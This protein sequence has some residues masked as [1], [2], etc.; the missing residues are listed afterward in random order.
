MMQTLKHFFIPHEGNNYHPHIL[1]TKR[2]FFYATAFLVMKLIVFLFALLLPLQVFVMPDVLKLQED[3]IIELTNEVRIR[4]GLSTLSRSDQLMTSSRLKVDDMIEHE[5]FDH[6]SPDGKH[7][8]DF[9]H[10]AGYIYQSAGENLGV[11]FLD[12][13]KLV[14]AWVDSPTHYANLVDTDYRDIGLGVNIGEYNGIPTA[15]VAQHFGMPEM[16][17]AGVKSEI[18]E[19]MDDPDYDDRAPNI[20]KDYV[21]TL[22]GKPAD[23]IEQENQIPLFAYNRDISRVYWKDMEDGSTEITA[24]AYIVG[25]IDEAIVRTNEYTINLFPSKD[26]YIYLGQIRVF[27]T[28]DQV[29][30][31]VMT[32]S[33]SIRAVSGEVLQDNIAWH[34]PKV[35]GPTPVEKYTSAKT[36]L[37]SVSNIFEVSRTVYLGFIIFFSIALL[38]K[39]LIE[40]RKQH[41]HVIFQ[42]VLL[43]GLLVVLFEF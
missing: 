8:R 22:L 42:T 30:E 9:L 31:V 26:P 40:F 19:K 23:E 43:I 15:F 11:G 16:Q 25:N 20:G 35:V 27:Q 17:V 38:L 21:I 13:E 34:E 33:I 28:P 12:A 10:Q 32:P 1:H 24:R 6:V 3:R 29:F 39:I 37:G 4:E 36:F 2:V 18:E 41:P 14:Q 5:Y 7:L